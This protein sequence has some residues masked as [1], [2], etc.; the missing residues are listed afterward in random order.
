MSISGGSC[1]KTCSMRRTLA[2]AAFLLLL[3]TPRAGGAQDPPGTLVGVIADRTGSR[4]PAATVVA[5]HRDTGLRRE[6]AGSA[7]GLYRLQLL[8][9]GTYRVTIKATGFGAAVR[10]A[11]EVTVGQTIRLDVR[12]LAS[13]SART[14]RP[15]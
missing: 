1:V 15:S 13:A 6:A 2:C 3:T 9:I 4:V 7:D 12:P 14:S 11:I 5:E 10:D 8:P